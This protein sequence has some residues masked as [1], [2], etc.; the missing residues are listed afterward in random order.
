MSHIVADN[1][2]S[3]GFN[4]CFYNCFTE[5]LTPHLTIRIP[6]LASVASLSSTT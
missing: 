2:K 4:F 5:S 1:V 3:A 6:L